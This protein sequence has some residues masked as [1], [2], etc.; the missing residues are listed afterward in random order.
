MRI[1]FVVFCQLTRLVLSVAV[2]GLRAEPLW[3][4]TPRIADSSARRPFCAN[5]QLAEARLGS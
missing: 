2:L 5:F 4:E 1:K 3:G